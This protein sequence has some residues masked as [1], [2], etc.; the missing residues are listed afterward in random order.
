MATNESQ[1]HRETPMQKSSSSSRTYIIIGV[2]ILAV[3]VV[4]YVAL[5]PGTNEGVDVTSQ[6]PPA[7]DT[8]PPAQ[9]PAADSATAPAPDAGAASGASGNAAGGE[10]APA[11]SN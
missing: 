2:L 8:A 1:K 6:P 7:T 10:P 5:M 11:T 3:L 9:P 4:A